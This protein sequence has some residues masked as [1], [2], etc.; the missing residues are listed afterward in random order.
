MRRQRHTR[1]VT[2]RPERRSVVPRRRKDMIGLPQIPKTPKV[3]DTNLLEVNE[4]VFRLY[5][6]F[7]YAGQTLNQLGRQDPRRKMLQEYLNDI[8]RR[9]ELVMPRIASKLRGRAVSHMLNSRWGATRLHIGGIRIFR[10]D[11]SFD[12]EFMASPDE[13]NEPFRALRKFVVFPR[14]AGNEDMIKLIQSRI[15]GAFNFS[16]PIV[17]VQVP[18]GK[19]GQQ[20]ARTPTTITPIFFDIMGT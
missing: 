1:A 10:L 12:V 4:H 16:T 5:G 13:R 7:N 17:T 9:L 14:K 3:T 6:L 20:G 8:T 11:D 18:L 15:P 19:D 2:R